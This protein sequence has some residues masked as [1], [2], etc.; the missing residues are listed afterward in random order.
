MNKKVTYKV[1]N[2][3]Q[4]N[5]SLINRGNLTLWFSE[6]AIRS[7]YAPK[8]AKGRGRDFIYSDACI[9][10][11]LTLRTLFHF[12][13]RATQGFLEGLIGMLGLG[14]KTPHYSRLSRRAQDLQI[15]ILRMKKN[16]QTPTDLVIDSTGLKI[17]GEGEW[18]IRIHGKQKRRTWRKYHVSVDPDTHEVVA[19]ELTHANVHD[20][21]VINA[22]LETDDVIGEV[23]ADGAYTHKNCFD[24]IAA[25]NGNPFIH[26]RT[27]TTIVRKNPSDGEKLRNQLIR[28]RQ[29]MG[30]KEAWKKL[31]GYHRRS[32]VETHMFRLKTILGSSLKSRKFDN[33]KIEAQIMASILNRMTALG[34]PKTIPI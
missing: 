33:Q 26:V 9:E 21:A 20:S 31:S 6:D 4:Y 28:D 34:M 25:K 11:A 17:Y 12:S 32:L 19:M 27:G 16:G 5:R 29:K 13:L 18:K 23:Y 7:W 30:G 24:T 22:V 3:K 1:R 8:I 10:M 14:L 15:Q 2:W